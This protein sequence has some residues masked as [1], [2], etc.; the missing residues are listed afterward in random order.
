M[1][2]NKL[3]YLFFDL[4]N[5]EVKK[6]GNQLR[7]PF[8]QNNDKVLGLYK[9]LVKNKK[10]LV[11]ENY[12][13]IK[14]EAFTQLYPKEDYASSKLRNVMSSLYALVE[15]FLLLETL[16]KEKE[17]RNAA[18]LNLYKKRNLDKLLFP[19]IDLE[20]KALTKGTVRGTSYCEPLFK[21]FIPKHINT[22]KKNLT[23]FYSQFKNI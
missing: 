21:L 5:G 13:A 20:I 4:S 14:Q 10:R 19:A 12:E 1:R 3:F 17:E 7:H 23:K 11:A 15:D 22:R 2:K 9:Y 18:L 16:R 8:F 6:L